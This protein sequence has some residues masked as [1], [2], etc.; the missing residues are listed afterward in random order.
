[1]SKEVNER[2]K[3]AEQVQAIVPDAQ[4]HV[5][6]TYEHQPKVDALANEKW[7]RPIATFLSRAHQEEVEEGVA[8]FNKWFHQ[9]IPGEKWTLIITKGDQVLS[10]TRLW[11]TPYCGNIWLH[12]GLEVHEDL[13]RKGLAKALTKLAMSLLKERQEEALQANI[14]RSNRAS[15]SLHTSLGFEEVSQGSL[16]SFGDFITSTNRYRIK[17]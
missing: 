13:R 9:D 12:E 8:F 3:L 14:H 10:L 16:N 11:K 4:I 15:I 2:L 1:M 6:H 17:L 5:L 7:S